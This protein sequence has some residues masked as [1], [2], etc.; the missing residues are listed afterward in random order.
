MPGTYVSTSSNP[1]VEV[2]DTLGKS[3]WLH[4]LEGERDNTI[5]DGEGLHRCILVHNGEDSSTLIEGFKCV[6]GWS[7][8]FGGGVL[9]E[10]SSPIIRNLHITDCNTPDYDGSGLGCID[11]SS[12]TIEQ[13]LI[14]GNSGQNGAGAY[15]KDSSPSII[16]CTITANTANN[17]GGGAYC[18]STSSP[19]FDN[20]VIENNTAYDGAGIFIGSES[21]TSIYDCIITGNSGTRGG[22]I[23]Y[24]TNVDTDLER[25]R[26]TGNTAESGG[27]IF[28]AGIGTTTISDCEICGNSTNQI[29]GPGEFWTDG[30]GNTFS[31]E[32]LPD[33]GNGACCIGGTCSPNLTAE[34]CAALLGFFFLDDLCGD[35]ESCSTKLVVDAGGSDDP[36]AGLF[37]TIQGAIDYSH[38]GFV[39]NVQP[40]TYYGTGDSVITLPSHGITITGVGGAA[41]TTIQGGS[42][43]RG[44][45]GDGCGDTGTVIQ[46]LTIRDGRA[47]YGAGVYLDTCS[48]TFIDCVIT[49]N[50]CTVDGG[51]VY[52]LNSS[53][54]FE[55]CTISS[56]T[57]GP[58]GTLGWGGGVYLRGSGIG[59]TM[60]GC[61][62]DNNTAR[63]SGGGILFDDNESVEYSGDITITDCIFSGNTGQSGPGGGGGV[64]IENATSTITGSTFTGN[65]TGNHGGG[66]HL[67]NSDC[68][69]ESCDFNDNTSAQDGGGLFAEGTSLTLQ[70]CTFDS[71]RALDSY[72]YGG[73]ILSTESSL[74]ITH[75]DFLGNIA[76]FAGGAIH[77]WS[78]GGSATY[79]TCTFDGNIAG[80]DS[81]DNVVAGDGGA[82]RLGGTTS[83][84][85]DDCTFTNNTAHDRG[86][87]LLVTI[88]DSSLA[89]LRNCSITGNTSLGADGAYGG[90]LGGGGW[91]EELNGAPTLTG[92]VVCAN[93]PD[94]ID[95]TWND[96]GGNTIRTYCDYWVID[97]LFDDDPNADF[98]NIQAAINRASD[99]DEILVMPG[100]YVSTS[101]NPTVEVVDTLGKSIW[102]HGL[103]G[104]RDNTIIDGEGLH[105]CILVHNGEDSSTLIEGFKCVRGWSTNF[106]GGVL[107]EASSPII[108][109]LHI[110]DCNTPDYDGS[111]LGCI[112]GSSPT[113]EQCLI[114]GNSG[115]NGAG[116][117]IKD[118]SPSI[119]GCTITANT[120]NNNGGG[121]YCTSTSSPVFD[122]CVIENNT[123]Y[124]GAGIFIGSESQT[125]IYDCIITGN[126]GTRGGGIHYST[127]VDTDLERCRITGNTAESG[128]GIFFAGI[129]TTTISDCEICGNSTNQIE[130]PGEFWTD[131]G[132]NTFS[133]EC[134]PDDGNGAC[135]IG[136]TCSPNLT[137]EECAALLGFF[138]LDDL[139]GDI[140]SCSTKLVVDAGGSDDPNAGL[141]TTIQGAIDYSHDGFV[142]NVQPGTY[143][144]TGDSVITLPSHGITLNGASSEGDPSLYVIDGEGQR[145]GL[146]GNGCGDN[147]TVID[148]LTFTSGWSSSNGGGLYLADCN[149]TIRNCSILENSAKLDGGGIFCVQSSPVI[150][151][152]T[153]ERNSTVDEDGGGMLCWN[154]CTPLISNTTFA[155]NSAGDTSGGIYIGSGSSLTLTDCTVSGNTADDSSGVGWSSDST[156]TLSGTVVCGNSS[157]QIN[158][159]TGYTDLGGNII[160]TYC[161]N[162]GPWLV[163]DDDL[164]DE[165]LADFTN[166]QDAIDAASN[167][168][169][170][171]VMP[172][173]YTDTQDGHVV[174]MKG[175]AVWLHGLEGE[176]ENTIIDGQDARRGIACFNDEDGMTVI[177]H[178]TITKGFAVNFDY[179]LNGTIDIYDD[180]GG[181]IYL[182]ESSP[183]FINCII[184]GNNATGTDSYGGG[185]YMREQSHPEFESCTITGNHAE[186]QGGGVD[187]WEDCDPMFD[188]CE[189][190]GNTSTGGGGF[191][192]ANSCRP[193]FSNCRI[194]N[195]T[196]DTDGGGI[197]TGNCEITFKHCLI[198]GNSAIG[199]GGGIFVETSNLQ[200]LE[201]TSVCNN[202]PEQIVGTYTDNGGN[203]ISDDECLPDEGNGACCVT[204]YPPC[205]L[206]RTCLPNLSETE[207]TDQGGEFFLGNACEQISCEAV[208]WRTEDG[209]NGNW[210][211]RTPFLDGDTFDSIRSV[212]TDDGADLASITSA[213]ENAFL[214]ELAQGVLGSGVIFGTRVEDPTCEIFTWTDGSP[215]GFADWGESPPQPDCVPGQPVGFY[216]DGWHDLLLVDVSGA[217]FE[218]ST[219]CNGDGIVD[220]GQI[221][222]GDL[223]DADCNGIPDECLPVDGS[224]ACCVGGV[225]TD[226][227]TAQDCSDNLGFFYNQ[228]LCNDVEPCSTKLVV[229]SAGT[230]DPNAGLFTTIQG[231]ID[232][233][234]DGMTISVMPGTYTGNGDSVVTLPA[235]GITLNGASSE[236]DPSLY[237]ID[238]EGV[239][240][241]LTGIGCGDTGT[242]IQ[243]L[244]FINGYSDHGAGISLEYCSAEIRN[245][246]FTNGTATNNDGN[247]LG[248]GGIFLRE[249]NS[250]IE[251]CT[252]NN[253]GAAR[254][255]GGIYCH[256]STPTITNCHF[257][258]NTALAGA[259]FYSRYTGTNAT[260][261]ECTFQS[262]V[263]ARHGGGVYLE[264]A[265]IAQLTNCLFQSN[266]AAGESYQYHHGGGMIVNQGS[267]AT[268]TGCQFTANTAID[269]GGLYAYDSTTT[270]SDC[271]FTANTAQK[272]GGL[273]NDYF[274]TMTLSACIF[275]DNASTE[276]GGGIKSISSELLLTDCTIQTNSAGTFG[277]GIQWGSTEPSLTNTVVCGNTPDQVY[278]DSWIDNGGN[279][280]RTNCDYWV[281]D[282]L[283]DDDPERRLR[284]YSGRSRCRQRRRR[285]PRHAGDV[286][287]RI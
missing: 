210:Y 3:I 125:S 226:A 219:D 187:A 49:G 16:G 224:G 160:R 76:K 253:N 280:I 217:L 107:C 65:S 62:I 36:N 239:R 173:T 256:T 43:L 11:G 48:P 127:N 248:G 104:E 120:A 249:S 53:P 235:H 188:D 86:G 17:N 225:C 67:L 111:G 197:R 279:L 13:C 269:G 275:T 186:A 242:V 161:E 223:T 121:A 162:A 128:G 97:D 147:G 113:I 90:G 244:T 74:S 23:H 175:K 136:G 72:G 168:D 270:L 57:A 215:F 165:P 9:C 63:N 148:G 243:G 150:E 7:T 185:V 19:V 276:E 232:Y 27:G 109:N 95:G 157:D 122:N 146:L 126:S 238:G 260:L 241:G 196:S 84:L 80:L 208:Q 203:Y 41:V 179:D 236:G 265:S 101:S 44:I 166:I 38:D 250:Q 254:D 81:S 61:T 264:E 172:G 283:Y 221:L 37:T 246:T 176:T 79:T 204:L 247:P 42:G 164:L 108:R 83:T 258:G 123:A 207:C 58:D 64:Y 245:C 200:V 124:D 30:G 73:A 178:F 212:A 262:N 281:V 115:Q 268:L 272:G 284:H 151:N 18:T 227:V 202:T 163:V 199:T 257:E 4:G 278:P 218:W 213:E 251:D 94:Q 141:F 71:N 25:C 118:S 5:I 40:G 201:N 105:R 285:D 231:A 110:T 51:G 282:D 56:N 192:C 133:D 1:T 230:D 33:D 112:D 138:F 194:I 182:R 216:E 135:C 195:N 66:L 14:V 26:I 59:L 255:G 45:T 174:D 140:E 153:I 70:G 34:E 271:T 266:S 116:A 8:N 54:T 190:S 100:T 184:Q 93:S 167:G 2:V 267:D 52:G 274:S 252:F 152:C 60:S 10:A 233:S 142:I 129:G 191:H 15:I 69:M 169:E 22:G 171:L 156:L 149:P 198:S 137:A 89:E 209:G 180:E 102:L 78:T 117:Y 286:Y 263:A 277:G 28:F 119:I 32:C 130:G 39:I 50:I 12:P 88:T 205:D 234:H 85:F 222:A 29:E 31:D 261:V 96:N 91:S 21:Q 143:Y 159:A 220:Y 145:R 240:R 273:F 20:C 132:G 155:D 158:P 92:T 229:D 177:E 106:G 154:L 98:D 287:G 87:G 189:L 75:T 35:I 181:G 77:Q 183:K 206:Y 214:A 237:V 6:R 144:G 82:V 55:N 46:G 134:L 24:S 259:G 68:T 47:S 170:I 228:Q 103:E 114:V 193:T 99:G 139:C 211:Q 131:G